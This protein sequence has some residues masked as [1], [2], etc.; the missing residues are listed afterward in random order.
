[1]HRKEDSAMMIW[2]RAAFTVVVGALAAAPTL[3][4]QRTFDQHFNAPPGGQLTLNTDVGTVLIAGR[5]DRGLLVH[6]DMSGSDGFLARLQVTA[7]QNAQGVTVTGHMAHPSVLD[8][9]FDSWFDL[10]RHKVLY[11]VSVPRDYPVN[12]H[13]SGGGLDVRHLNASV[14]GTTSGG[15]VT[16]RDV[17][18]SI[19]ARTSGGGI[20]AAD[21]AGPTQLRTSGGS[22]EVAGCTGDLDAETAGGGIHLERIDGKVRAE[23][24]GGSVDAE[25]LANRGVS[26]I[27]S[28]GSISLLLPANVQGSIDAHTSGG[29]AESALAVRSEIVSRNELRGTINGGG[30]PIFLRTSGGSIHVRALN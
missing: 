11:T 30:E 1:V 5:D 9:W 28:G 24:A 22:I 3:A 4:A 25:L 19:Y 26:L 14:H 13:T 16:L 27:T 17:R 6:V 15:H 23:T 29:R 7:V 18:G 8:W 10:G 21:L 2:T 20:D 12:I